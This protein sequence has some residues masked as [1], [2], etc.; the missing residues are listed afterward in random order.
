MVMDFMSGGGN[1]SIVMNL[2]VRSGGGDFCILMGR[3]VALMT[4]NEACV[5]TEHFGL[6][7]FW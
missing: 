7:Y 6:Q 1:D 2:H 3:M 4:S 5:F